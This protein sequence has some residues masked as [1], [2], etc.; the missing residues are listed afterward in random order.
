MSVPTREAFDAPVAVLRAMGERRLEGERDGIAVDE[1]LG[2][3]GE[4]VRAEAS[5]GHRNIPSMRVSKDALRH[6]LR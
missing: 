2:A 6:D 4:Q 5:G 1:A 3:D